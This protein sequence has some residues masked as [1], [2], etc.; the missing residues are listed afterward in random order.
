MTT[1]IDALG[2]LAGMAVE[3]LLFYVTHVGDIHVIGRF[4]REG[5]FTG[6]NL[7]KVERNLLSALRPRIDG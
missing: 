1:S 6:T 2:I 3:S 4:E 5:L 7:I